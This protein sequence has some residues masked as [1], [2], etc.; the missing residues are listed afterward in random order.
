MIRF[1]SIVLLAAVAAAPLS[2]Q[3]P[4]PEAPPGEVI[5]VG[6]FAHIVADLDASLVLYR[7]VLGLTVYANQPFAP[8]AAIA[9][10]G[11]TEG[12]QSRYVALRVPGMAL[13][14]ELIEYKDIQRKAQRPHFVDGGAANLSMRVRDL[15]ALFAKI[16]KVPGVTERH[17]DPGHVRADGLDRVQG[18]SAQ[19]ALGPHARSGHRHS[20]T[21][22]CATRT[23]CC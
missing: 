8:N 21:R 7:D 16:G 10:L 22:S 12:G 14:I 17:D 1:V 20:A 13:G 23:T 2:A 4:R 11:A 5:G 9:K 15:D 18:H 19:G 3:Q 6:N